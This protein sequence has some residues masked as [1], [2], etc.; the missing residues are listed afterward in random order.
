MRD[1]IRGGSAQKRVAEFAAERLGGASRIA[2]FS[3]NGW[4]TH[5]NQDRSLG[6]ALGRLSDTI[7]TLRDGMG[8]QAW[9]KTAVV[10]MTEFGRTVRIN[11]T[12]GTDHG[13][14]GAMIMAGGAIRG[15]R[16]VSDWPGLAEA[17]LYA[18]RDLMPTRDLRAHAGWL[19]RGLFGLD[20]KVIER[21]I[22]PG[23]DLGP[24]PRLLL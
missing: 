5:D 12:S 13:T 21:D 15:G 23:L 17:D 2:A 11:G 7:L 9:G 1:D 18:R 10:A 19:I 24:D 6:R 14:G 8:P 4:D 20:T 16:V 22:F 3:I